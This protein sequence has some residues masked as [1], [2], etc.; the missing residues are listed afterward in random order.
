[1]EKI[2]A[3]FEIFFS[4][5]KLGLNNMEIL[6]KKR[7]IQLYMLYP[8]IRYITRRGKSFFLCVF[9]HLLTSCIN[10]IWH[11]NIINERIFQIFKSNLYE[12]LPLF[13]LSLLSWTLS[14]SALRLADLDLLVLAN[15][16]VGR[17]LLPL[18]SVGV[19][20]RK[21]IWVSLK[22]KKLIVGSSALWHIDI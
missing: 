21:A 13:S 20:V 17:L 19:P 22:K 8:G 1:M 11:I 10:I 2:H 4:F 15:D 12:I 3:W 7:R 5:Q 9:S 6:N 18:A 16:K 14:I